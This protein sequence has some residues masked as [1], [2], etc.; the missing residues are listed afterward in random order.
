MKLKNVK[1]MARMIDRNLFQINGTLGYE[2][3]TIAI[4][5]LAQMIEECEESEEIW[6]IELNYGGLDDLII[7]A[8]WHY[9]HW[10]DGQWSAGYA[11]LSALGNV[12][13]PGFGGVEINETY[14]E[15]DNMA[16]E[17]FDKRAAK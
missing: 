15:L 17:H 9:S 1:S 16:S 8:Y 5:R 12:F 11:A 14:Q 4:T 3:M 2:R 13:S 10:H 6:W 7:G